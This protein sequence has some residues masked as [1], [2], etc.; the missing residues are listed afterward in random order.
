MK[1]EP[2]K[3]TAEGRRLRQLAARIPNREVFDGFI[4]ATPEALRAQVRR[5]LIPYL[6][7]TLNADPE[8]AEAGDQTEASAEARA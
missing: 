8:A 4:A 6:R 7:F 5:E 3:R 2:R 1:G